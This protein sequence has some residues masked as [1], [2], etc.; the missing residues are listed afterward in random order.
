MAETGAYTPRRVPR[1]E[2]WWLRG[3]RHRVWCWGPDGGRPLVLLHGWMDTGQTWQFLVDALASERRVIAPDWRGFGDSEWVLGGYYF[4]DYLADLDA[5]LE[6]VGGEP[7]DLVGHSMGG[8]VAGLYA[9]VRPTRIRRLALVEGFGARARDASEA[10]ENYARWLDHWQTPPALHEP[11][12]LENFAGR[13]QLRHPH[14][15]NERALF[16]A[17]AWLRPEGDGWQIRADP[18][19]KRRNPVLYRLEEAEAC[20]RC[21][22]APAL[23]VVGNDS[24]TLSWFGG[25]EELKRRREIIGAEE[26]R[27]DRAGHMIHHD[28]P[29]ALAGSLETFLDAVEAPARCC[30]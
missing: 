28:Q 21:I 4:P 5:L 18:G 10:P 11:D 25:E 17:A 14:L 27:I 12:S 2:T 8:N 23:W 6:R 1:A 24:R 29:E 16:V 30:D 22:T 20:W 15:T 7:V 26:V 9:G 3:V 19:H 13:L